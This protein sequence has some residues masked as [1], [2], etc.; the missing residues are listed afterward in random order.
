MPTVL[1]FS[2]DFMFKAHTLKLPINALAAI[3][4]RRALDSA[5]IGRGRL[6]EARRLP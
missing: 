2:Y 5:T 4:L 1:L 6:L 3:N